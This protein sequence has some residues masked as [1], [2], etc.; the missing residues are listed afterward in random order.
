MFSF[1]PVSGSF[2]RNSR[3]PT[4]GSFNLKLRFASLALT[5]SLAAI[6]A[7]SASAATIYNF[8]YTLN[9]GDVIFW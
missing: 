4:Q 8:S 3:K 2:C 7:T 6:S 5:F 1:S 9:S